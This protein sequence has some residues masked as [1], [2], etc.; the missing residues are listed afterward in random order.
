MAKLE[1]IQRIEF[2][3]IQIK[4]GEFEMKGR[5]VLTNGDVRSFA[6]GGTAERSAQEEERFAQ[7]IAMQN[8]AESYCGDV[9]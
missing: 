6:V 2:D 5:A 8:I 1:T 3:P 4:D 7:R 9:P